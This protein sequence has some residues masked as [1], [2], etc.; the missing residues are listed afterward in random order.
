MLVKKKPRVWTPG[1]ILSTVLTVVGGLSAAILFSIAYITED[2]VDA[3]RLF[4]LAYSS[5]SIFGVGV[6]L[7]FLLP[8]SSNKR[9][10]S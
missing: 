2:R 7:E 6:A 10:V 3:Q 9:G 8:P 4:G 1:L 5:I